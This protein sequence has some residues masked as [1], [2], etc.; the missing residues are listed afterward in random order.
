MFSNESPRTWLSLA[1][2]GIAAALIYVRASTHGSAVRS[3]ADMISTVLVVAAML[4]A[5]PGGG[6]L[7]R[8]LGEIA[9]DIRAGRQA[10]STAL[11]KICIVLAWGLCAAQ[12]VI[13]FRQ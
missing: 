11:Q 2:V 4:I 8:T 7:D 12:A 9:A 10:R 1:L 3:A 13:A 6:R 5:L